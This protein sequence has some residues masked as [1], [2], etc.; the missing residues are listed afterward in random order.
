VLRLSASWIVYVDES[1]DEGFRFGRGSSSWFVLTAVLLARDRELEVVKLIDV[2]RDKINAA[3]QPHHQTPAR[4]P[5]H[6][7]D[8][9]HDPRKFYATQIGTAALRIVSVCVHK[10]DLAEAEIFHDESRLY[11]YATRFLVERIS[12][13]CRDNPRQVLGDGSAEIVFSNR[14]S[15]DYAALCWYLENLAANKEAFD[16]RADPKVVRVDQ[17]LTLSPGK[18]MGLQIADAAACSIYLALEPNNYGQTEDAHLRAIS[19]RIYR[20]NSNPWGYGLK[21]IPRETDKKRKR[22]ELI[23]PLNSQ[24]GPEA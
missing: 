17:V 8:L 7:R 5:L 13:C 16:Y 20:H 2:V 18:R 10:P 21:I 22:G 4:K 6:F 23:I 1:G 12:W 24:G 3:Q 11:F 19:S 14:G 15:M 9:K